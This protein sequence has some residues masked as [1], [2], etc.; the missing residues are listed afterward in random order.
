M[1]FAVPIYDDNPVRHAPLVT[2]ALI[3]A[4]TGAWF[5]QIA[6]GEELAAFHYGMIPAALFGYWPPGV[7]PIPPWATLFTSMFLHGGWM[8]LISNMLFLWIFGNNIEDLLGKFRYLLLYLASGVVAAL[9]QGLSA[10]YS[11]IPMVGASGA[12]AGVLGAYLLTYPRANVHV[13]VWIVIFFWIVTVPAWVLLGFWFAMQV[14]SGLGTAASEPGVAFWAHVGG[15]VAGGGLFLMLRPRG[16]D[17]LQPRHSPTWTSVPPG[18]MPREMSGRRR[19]HSGSV[20]D[21][22]HRSSQRRPWE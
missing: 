16:V 7:Q 12:V 8:H 4:C 22:G 14:L 9:I 15:F 13:L 2:Y 1:V 18:A 6:A 11:Q 19:S 5:W 21:A 3:G 17:I 10:R 20:P